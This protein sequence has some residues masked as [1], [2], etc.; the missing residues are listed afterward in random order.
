[1]ATWK[2]NIEAST[3]FEW[4]AKTFSILKKK[5]QVFEDSVSGAGH[6]VAFPYQE[7]FKSPEAQGLNAVFVGELREDSKRYEID[8][9]LLLLPSQEKILSTTVWVDRLNRLEHF[10]KAAQEAFS[11]LVGSI[12]FDGTILRRHGYTV[13]LDRGKKDL[14]AGLFLPVFTLDK[15]KGELVL[16]ET[17]VIEVTRVETRLSFGKIRARE[18]TLQG[19]R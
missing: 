14:S 18:A 2:K 8:A 5:E 11:V 1:V 9:H 19:G 10:E 12:P 7:F 15:R 16:T 4:D 3:R 6:A 13:V 17:G